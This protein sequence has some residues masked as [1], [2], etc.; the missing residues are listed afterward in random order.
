MPADVSALDESVDSELE[1]LLDADT[2]AKANQDKFRDDRGK[3]DTSVVPGSDSEDTK[4]GAMTDDS[5]S[6]PSLMECDDYSDEN[7]T[8]EE[9]NAVMPLDNGDNAAAVD[10]NATNDVDDDRV[11]SI[12][13]AKSISSVS[14]ST[15][16][17]KAST[18]YRDEMKKIKGQFNPRKVKVIIY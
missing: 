2:H 4:D 14:V 8:D 18:D 16:S 5:G 1:A 7:D 15:D 11:D 6:I 10:D 13:T 17:S 9:S 12:V 3:I